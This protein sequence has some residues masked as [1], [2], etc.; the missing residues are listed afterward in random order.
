M[1]TD[2]PTVNLVPDQPIEPGDVFMVRFY[3][4]DFSYVA[5]EGDTA[6]DVKDAINKMIAWRHP[7][8]E[9]THD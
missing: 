6:K 5:K 7:S 2:Q 4:E 8:W 9:V 1:A 3:G